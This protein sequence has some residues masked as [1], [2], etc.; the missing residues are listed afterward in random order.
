MY[1]LTGFHGFHVIVGLLFLSYRFSSFENENVDNL[2]RRFDIVFWYNQIVAYVQTLFVHMQQWHDTGMGKQKQVAPTMP[3]QRIKLPGI[4]DLDIKNV[5]YKVILYVLDLRKLTLNDVKKKV[6]DLP[7]RLRALL[8]EI[9]HV[10]NRIFGESED[11]LRDIKATFK[12]ARDEILHGVRR[13]FK[14]KLAN[15]GLIINRLKG[16]LK[17]RLN[18]LKNKVFRR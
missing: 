2:H 3:E 15:L 12:E 7:V 9:N 16:K 14:E 6:H 4:T 18:D 8:L 5:V 11:M 1:V 17:E 10:L 13:A